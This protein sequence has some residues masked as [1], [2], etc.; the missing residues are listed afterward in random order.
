MLHL[1]KF[2]RAYDPDIVA[3]MTAAFDRVCECV[4]QRVNGNDDVKEKLAL[5]ILQHVDRGERDS[6]R[7]ADIALREWT[8]AG[9]SALR[10]RRSAAGGS[11]REG[12]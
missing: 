3:V 12:M 4:S 9:R 8:G 2:N 1:L 5:I 6:E 7:L 11:A 10:T